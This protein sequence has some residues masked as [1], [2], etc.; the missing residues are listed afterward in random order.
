M[1]KKNDDNKEKKTVITITWKT[2]FSN[3]FLL[4]IFFYCAIKIIKDL[5]VHG[6]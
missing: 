6:T 5:F 4:I 3:L 1:I 2:L